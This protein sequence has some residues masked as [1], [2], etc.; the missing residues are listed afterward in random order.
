MARG[1]AEE[2]RPRT[3]KHPL[4]ADARPRPLAE[5]QNQT[6]LVLT[7]ALL[8][9]LGVVLIIDFHF[10]LGLV[11]LTILAMAT[12]IAAIAFYG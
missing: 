6:P 8:V 12:V 10:T 11:L 3:E 1:M 5:D 2:K 4:A 7:V 9:V